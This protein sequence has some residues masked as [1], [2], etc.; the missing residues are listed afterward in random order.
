MIRNG[1]SLW[2]LRPSG[3][4]NNNDIS[5]DFCPFHDGGAYI[6][7]YDPQNN[8][9]FSGDQPPPI[10]DD[11]NDNN[12]DQHSPDV[13][14]YGMP[15]ANQDYSSPFDTMGTPEPE[16]NGKDDGGAIFASDGPLLPDP[17]QM[18]EEGFQRR[19]WRRLV[20]RSKFSTF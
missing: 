10:S 3:E 9:V 18:Q 17:I 1:I 12:N 20:S 6:P 2:F 19:E 5:S 15:M 13:Y 11:V 16:T 4:K 8:D 14:G 7:G